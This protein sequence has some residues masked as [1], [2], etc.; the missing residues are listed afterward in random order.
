M[1]K[2]FLEHSLSCN[3]FVVN[4]VLFEINL[5]IMLIYSIHYIDKISW[6]SLLI[7]GTILYN[8]LYGKNILSIIISHYNH[9]F[10]FII[11]FSLII[12]VQ[13]GEISN[14]YN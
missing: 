7:R 13:I 1:Y 3:L 2:Y 11:N 14:Y 4:V 10:I 9:H 5:K 12:M 8:E 6:M